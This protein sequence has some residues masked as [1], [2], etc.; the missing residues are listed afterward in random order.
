MIFNNKV[1]D[2]LKWTA[3]VLLPALATLILAVG[4]IW[5][6]ADYTVPIG[7]TVAAVATF[8]G[9]LVGVSSIK[10]AKLNAGGDDDVEA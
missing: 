9:A 1:Y 4:Q 7:A 6:L 2:V 10:Y 5:G 8:I 3:S